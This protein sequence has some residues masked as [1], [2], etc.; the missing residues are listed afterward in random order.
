MPYGI[1]CFS[2]TGQSLIDV[3][4]LGWALIDTYMA[5]DSGN[6]VR[7]Y[8]QWAG[9][10]IKATNQKKDNGGGHILHVSGTTV[11]AIRLVYPPLFTDRT[12]QTY[13]NV[14]VR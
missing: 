7:H 5:P 12:S 8:P 3:T 13:I 2:G 9:H 6:L 10:D 4:R 14:Y 11:T 1:K